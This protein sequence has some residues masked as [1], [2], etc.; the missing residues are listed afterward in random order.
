MT[1][2]FDGTDTAVE[3]ERWYGRNLEVSEG[4]VRVARERTPAY[5][6]PRPVVDDHPTQFTPVDFDLDE[7][8]D[9]YVLTAEAEIYR[10]D[11]RNGALR[12]LPCLWYS[13]D[14]TGG[15]GEGPTSE[16]IALGVTED[17]IYVADGTM[18]GVAAFSKH[19][20]QLRWI[21]RSIGG[22][23]F[24]EPLALVGDRR[25]G[26]LLDGGA[27]E[28]EGSV[29]ALTATGVDDE[30]VVDGLYDPS[31]LSLG[32]GGDLY[33]LDWRPGGPDDPAG[34]GGPDG[35]GAS[36][37]SYVVRR[38]SSAE[39]GDGSFTELE[40]DE[41]R[42]SADFDPR[43]IEAVEGRQVLIGVGTGTS[44]EWTPYRYLPA[45]EDGGEGRF[46]R[47]TS[48][49]RTC[50]ALLLRR[51][52]TSSLG[53]G[54]YA[55]AGPEQ[56]SAGG[57]EGIYFLDE[58]VRNRLDPVAGGYDARAWRRLDSGTPGVQWHRVETAQTLGEVGTQVRLKYRATD[59]SDVGDLEGDL[60]IAPSHADRLYEAGIA[61]AWGVLERPP[62][63]LAELASVPRAWIEEWTERGWGIVDEVAD[64]DPRRLRGIGGTYADR[65][66]DAGVTTV[67]DLLR[68]EEAEIV[69]IA[70]PR[71]GERDARIWLRRAGRFVDDAVDD[72]TGGVGIDP[73]SVAG[74]EEV[75]VDRLSVLVRRG[76]DW[77][78]RG[79]GVSTDEV[80]EW[81]ERAD[82]H[83]ELEWSRHG[84]VPSLQN[85]HDAL[86]DGAEGRYL[87]VE[88]E[89][90]GSE[91]SSPMV[92]SFRAYFPR[93]SYL[94]YLP[95]IYREDDRS[96]EFLE[97]FLSVF[98]STFVGIEEDIESVTRFL[99]SAGIPE[100]EVPW[101]GAWLGVEIDETWPESSQR[102][103]IDRAPELFR[104][105]GTRDGVIETL[106]IYLG[107]SV[108]LPRAWE[109]ALDR[110]RE[111][112]HEEDGGPTATEGEEAR[113]RKEPSVYVLEYSDLD[114]IDVE[115]A[116]EPYV[117]G[118]GCPQCFL[119]LV[120]PFLGDEAIGAIERIVQSGTP[121]HAVGRAVGL[122]PRIQLAGASHPGNTYLGINS[123]LTEREFVVEESTLGTDSVL[124]ER[125]RFSQLE[126][127]SRLGTDTVMT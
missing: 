127:K 126:L 38:F 61:G 82:A 32:G 111:R 65:L 76:P 73:I 88:L 107:D 6:S 31:D 45:A 96:A 57:D 37:P 36:G 89:L 47:I 55:I 120:P 69:D 5:V 78:T 63:L 46:E 40:D 49:K 1:F 34:G 104:K 62:D 22:D 11:H 67:A 41:V 56:G 118:L 13:G 97:R 59:A 92:D 87:W 81:I 3:W 106:E 83:L 80:R 74:L 30:R 90:V 44:R 54:L 77:L 7:C 85:P 26:Y 18:G 108:S 117:A 125:E 122:Q 98:E 29:V 23:P 9:L 15:A 4:A 33:V 110:E 101:L 112:H 103:L 60:G 24:E 109:A 124:G 58:V 14:G 10:Y 51:R 79:L 93:Q 99:D 25:T 19:L 12:R 70:T 42:V 64:V 95:A 102:E 43:C 72:W 100:E 20:H 119:V 27:G 71:R 53:K 115:A 68:L 91:A 2:A 48:F 28:G 66:R 123:A 116:R 17:S 52:G 16:P 86:L 39:S 35:E 8:G 21:A 121:A 75:G 105:H 114:C 50:S 113:A 84:P 94:R